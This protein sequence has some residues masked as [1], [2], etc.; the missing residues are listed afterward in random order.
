MEFYGVLE[1]FG[2]LLWLQVHPAAWQYSNGAM[3][4]AGGSVQ[5]MPVTAVQKGPAC[6]DAAIAISFLWLGHTV[7]GQHLEGML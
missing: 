1:W 3:E 5:V 7:R 6:V 4:G 2:R